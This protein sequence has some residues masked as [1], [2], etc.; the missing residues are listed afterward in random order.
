MLAHH[1]K[2]PD[3]F[4]DNGK[5]HSRVR[6]ARCHSHLRPAGPTGLDTAAALHMRHRRNKPPC[7]CAFQRSLGR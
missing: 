5:R 7:F 1:A 4:D 6:G 2:L 3:G